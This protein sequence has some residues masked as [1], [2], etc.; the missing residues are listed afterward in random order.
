MSYHIVEGDIVTVYLRTDPCTPVPSTMSLPTVAVSAGG[1]QPSSAAAERL[2]TAT[3]YL[4]NNGIAAAS[5]IA[6]AALNLLRFVCKDNTI[7]TT[8]TFFLF[9]TIS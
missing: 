1:E 3:S 4:L 8:I 5:L 2:A 6:F 9:T 7:T